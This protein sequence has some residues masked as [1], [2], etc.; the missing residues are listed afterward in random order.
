MS[1]KPKPIFKS[2][3]DLLASPAVSYWLKDR[4]R[5]I[6]SRDIVDILHDTRTLLAVIERRLQKHE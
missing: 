1:D 5:E 3:A 6:D 4:I 2:D